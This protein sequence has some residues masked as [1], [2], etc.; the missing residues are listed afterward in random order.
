M[1]DLLPCNDDCGINY[2]KYSFGQTD[3][4]VVIKV[5]LP[6]GTSSRSVCVDIKVSSLVIGLK[7]ETPFL[8][9]ELFRPVKVDECTWCIEDKKMLVVTLI[10]TNMQYE[11]WW[12]CVT[13]NEKQMDMKTF[14]PPSKHISELDDSTQATIA[15]MMF[16]QRQKRLNLPTSDELR[17]QELAHGGRASH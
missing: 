16:D 15:K 9:G 6:D 14:K 7:N 17:F 12:P 13:T 3:S 5:P 1:S 11:E 4:E 10:K 8:S 2:E